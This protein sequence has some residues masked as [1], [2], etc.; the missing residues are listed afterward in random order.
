MD[1]AHPMAKSAKQKGKASPEPVPP[2]WRAFAAAPLTGQVLSILFA[3]L[4]LFQCM[5]LPLVGKAA[6]NGSGSPGAERAAW[7]GT[8]TV[9]FTTMLL[10]TI[11]TGAAAVASKRMRSRRDGS[12][13]PRATTGLLVLSGVLLLVQLAGLLK[14]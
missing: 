14:I 4:F 13:L 10:I 11:V 6:M 7:A 9:F 1:N 12:P 2:D 3:L 5:I 8:N